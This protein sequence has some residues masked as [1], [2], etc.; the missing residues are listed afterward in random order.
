MPKVSLRLVTE[1]LGVMVKPVALVS[2]SQTVPSVL[3]NVRRNGVL[4]T[5]TRRPEVVT[6]SVLPSTT[7]IGGSTQFLMTVK[8]A[9]VLKGTPLGSKRTRATFASIRFNFTTA[10]AQVKV[11]SFCELLNQETT[12]PGS[13]RLRAGRLS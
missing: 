12:L 6:V 3:R 5:S 13:A 4:D 7:V 9:F 2:V 8:E 1:P 11:S 10:V